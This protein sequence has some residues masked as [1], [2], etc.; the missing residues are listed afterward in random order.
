MPRDR[1]LTGQQINRQ[2]NL[3]R[4]SRALS[5]QTGYLPCFFCIFP[6]NTTFFARRQEICIDLTAGNVS[7][8]LVMVIEMCQDMLL[9]ADNFPPTKA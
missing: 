2:F 1:A 3:H 8:L 5:K 9:M 4:F 6:R 7:T